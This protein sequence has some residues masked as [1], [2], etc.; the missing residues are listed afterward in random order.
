MPAAD[1][2]LLPVCAVL[3]LLGIVFTG[4]SWRRGRRGRVIQGIGLTLAPVGLYLSGLLR[5]VWNGVGAVLNWISTT[6]FSPVIWFG[7]GLL[8]LCVVLWMVGA[9]VT[10]RS[11]ARSKAVSGS[12]KPAVSRG[13]PAAAPSKAAPSA[14]A[15]KGQQ[16]P[17]DDDMAEIE[18]L[19]KSRGIE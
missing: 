3:A 10:R 8:G 9:V 15:K 11:P 19:L 16:A 17:V 13:K 14:Q 2:W 7:L 18:A 6:A 5:L 4:I 12:A 1:I